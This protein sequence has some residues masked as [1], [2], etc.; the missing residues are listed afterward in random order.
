MVSMSLGFVPGVHQEYNHTPFP[1]QYTSEDLSGVLQE[2]SL[3]PSL[4][5]CQ[6]AIQQ[7]N[8]K[9]PREWRLQWFD[10]A[11]MYFMY[12]LHPFNLT[13]YL[14]V[15]FFVCFTVHL[16][17]CAF[18]QVGLYFKGRDIL[19]KKSYAFQNLIGIGVKLSIC[20]FC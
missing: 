8:G 4:L 12:T 3:H 9:A 16:I 11:N 1:L 2:E 17:Y 15:A 13:R 10:A 5:F 19:E 20:Y 6:P 7:Q 14:N 18:N